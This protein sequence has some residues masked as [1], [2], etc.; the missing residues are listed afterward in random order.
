MT[1]LDFIVPAI[2]MLLS[3]YFASVSFNHEKAAG[4]VIITYVLSFLVVI[5]FSDADLAKRKIQSNG[6]N[7]LH[8]SMLVAIFIFTVLLTFNVFPRAHNKTFKVDFVNNSGTV[9]SVSMFTRA[10]ATPLLFM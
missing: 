7:Y 8:I 6:A 4:T 5:L 2:T 1:E 9:E 3:A 10:M